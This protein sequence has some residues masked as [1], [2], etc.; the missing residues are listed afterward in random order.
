[1]KF[2]LAL[3]ATAFGVLSSS[4][5]V[6]GLVP[7]NCAEFNDH[8]YCLQTAPANGWAP[9]KAAAESSSYTCPDGRSVT[10]RMATFATQEEA[11][12]ALDPAGT[13]NS[14]YS[15]GAWIGGLLQQG[16]WE[17]SYSQGTLAATDPDWA[18]NEPSNYNG[19]DCLNIINGNSPGWNDGYCG[20]PNP[21]YFAEYDCTS[22]SAGVGGDPHF[23]VR[24]IACL[25]CRW[26]Q[27]KALSFLIACHFVPSCRLP[28]PFV[29]SDLGR[30]LV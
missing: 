25:L 17:W 11:A 19:E 26:M 18:P 29:V 1:M 23:K 15:G 21:D 8:V 5:S 7:S 16:A 30:Q 9:G 24:T 3:V 12:W 10:G 4:P 13:F 27:P 2:S 28:L 20:Y 22:L 6:A 14:L